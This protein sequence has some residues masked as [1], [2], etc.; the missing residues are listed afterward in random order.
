MPN[1]SGTMLGRSISLAL[2]LL[3][4]AGAVV[5]AQKKASEKPRR[6][7]VF[8]TSKSGLPTPIDASEEEKER[9]RKENEAFQKQKNF[10]EKQKQVNPQQ[11]N[12]PEQKWPEPKEYPRKKKGKQTSDY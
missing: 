8:D 1:V 5:F 10:P 9:I 11:A 7:P 6:D 4:L 3:A 12:E 2:A